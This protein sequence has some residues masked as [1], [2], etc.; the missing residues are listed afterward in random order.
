MRSFI[1][2]VVAPVALALA[3]AAGAGAAAAQGGLDYRPV[4]GAMPQPGEPRD[5]GDLAELETYLDGVVKAE[6]GAR[7]LVG[8]AISI[9]K[10]GEVIFAKGYG[11]EDLERRVPVDPAM[12]LFRPGS[13]SKLFTWTAI[14][15]LVEQ[16]KIDLDADVNRYLTQFQIPEAFGAPV[17]IRN[18]LTHSGG[19]EDGG[20]GYLFVESPDEIVPLAESLARH[21][22]GRVRPPTT[23]FASGTGVA[24]SNYGT[25]L[26]GLIVANVSGMPFEEYVE[27]HIFEPLDMT[28][29]TFRE[30][31]PDNLAERMA[32]G[33]LPKD[34]GFAP[35]GFEYIANFGPAGALSA[36][37]ADM[38]RFMIAHLSDGAF[39]DRRIL[40]ADTARLMHGRSLSPDPAVNGMALGFYE[41]WING[42]RTIGHGGATNYF[43]TELMLLPEAN[44]GLFMTFNAPDGTR[45]A[46]NIKKA[47][48][49]RYFPAELPQVT[50]PADFAKRAADY[51]GSYRGLRRSYTT[52]EAVLSAFGDT[53]VVPMPDNTLLISDLLGET[54]RW[55]EIRPDVF[56]A[57]DDDTTVAFKRDG[58]GRVTHL[59]GPFTVM[60]SEKLAWYETSDFHMLLVAVAVILF[61]SMIISL[62]YRWRADREGPAR[63]RLARRVLA[64]VAVL[65][66]LFLI[67]AG[68]GLASGMERLIFGFPGLFRLALALPLVALPLT[69]VALVLGFFAWRD[70]YWKLAGRIHFT[71]VAVAATAFLWSLH[72]WNLLGYRFG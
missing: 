10:D 16:G 47:F 64:A 25:A 71:L 36:T 43:K 26:A 6:M 32:V 3:L 13:V 68:V 65:D 15:Q 54:R 53:K 2:K 69:I 37:A 58:A 5:L 49:D 27:R 12:T 11:F 40:E 52:A 33:Y 35:F 19:F 44:L 45:A 48:M 51:A 63:A 14:M 67:L 31:L 1:T 9:V 62:F 60:P 17:T 57:V 22:P 41:T 38:A 23:D 24:Y 39:E 8:A 29:S 20:I 42:R 55:V 30:P 50:P 18:L 7:K 59:V 61:I 72:F 21:I 56:R 70:R 4:D 28:R 34:G 46:A 66:L